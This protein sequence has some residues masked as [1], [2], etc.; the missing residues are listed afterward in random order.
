MVRALEDLFPGLR[1]TAYQI[2][3]PPDPIYNCIAWAAGASDSWWWPIGDPQRVYW[4]AGVPREET[5]EAVRAVFTT[6]G[7][8][9]C[10]HAE[11]E[12]GFEKV[13]LFA[14]AAGF[15]TH[16]ARQLESGRWTD[17]GIRKS[18]FW[19]NPLLPVNSTA[20]AYRTVSILSPIAE[21]GP[22]R[23]LLCRMRR[24][25]RSMDL[26]MGKTRCHREVP[27]SAPAS[28]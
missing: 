26:H 23:S 28:P 25:T 6:L 3:G 24:D 7:F 19:M 16:V 1:G 20:G 2:K 9:V 15:P 8:A 4:P 18:N 21:S 17:L 14:N 12:P 22:G 10:D 27:P 13:G 5:L 11:P